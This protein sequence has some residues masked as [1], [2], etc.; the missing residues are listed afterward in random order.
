MQM[1]RLFLWL[2]DELQRDDVAGQSFE[3]L[4]TA[5]EHEVPDVL[6]LTANHLLIYTKTKRSYLL[7]YIKY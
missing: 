6:K 1:S 7:R 2:F 5:D 4:K 3:F